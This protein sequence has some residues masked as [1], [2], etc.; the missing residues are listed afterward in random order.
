MKMGQVNV[1]EIVYDT[2]DNDEHSARGVKLRFH[3]ICVNL[4]CVTSF[5]EGGL[6]SSPRG[7]E[8]FDHLIEHE[9][10]LLCWVDSG[11]CIFNMVRCT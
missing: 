2:S 1:T 10:C 4:I 9:A 8:S 5:I 11:L 7:D 3:E 6:F